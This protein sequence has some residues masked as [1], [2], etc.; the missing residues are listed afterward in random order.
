[1][2]GT[3]V[4]E[5]WDEG[6]ALALAAAVEGDSEHTMARAMRRTAEERR[7]T[8]PAVAEFEA[9]KGRGVRATSD[10]RAVHVGGPRL[11]EMLG[12]ELPA[13]IS[14]FSTEASA[15]G[16]SVVYL[17]VGDQVAA[18]LALAD[19]IR[20]ESIAAIQ[21]LHAM[22]IQVA[23]LTGDSQAVAKSVAED[24]G[25]DTYFAEVL[26]EDKANEIKKL[27]KE[28]KLVGMVGDGI[29]DAPALIQ[30]DVGIAM[31]AGTDVAMESAKIVLIRNDPR[32]V[33]AALKLSKLTITKIKQNL[34]WAFGYNAIGIPIAAGILYPF[35]HR[36]LIT[37]E[38]AAAFMALSSVSVTTNS[39]LMKR[40]KLK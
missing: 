16:Q 26:P 24:L 4:A 31:G 9:L 13:A 38:L 1:V 8:L 22:G 34:L 32:D 23:M 39:L 28:G 30:S 27:Q 19:V 17:I 35:F 36:I 10:G 18:G 14:Q 25:I 37:P 6:R 40:S 29:N 21:A 33:V 20:S 3:R 11:L 7:L 5:G 15:K 12:L 2:V